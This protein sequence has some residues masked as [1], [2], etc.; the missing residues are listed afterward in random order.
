M[1]APFSLSEAEKICSRFQD[2]VGLKYNPDNALS[3][4]IECVAVTPY[5]ATNKQ[6][7][8]LYY[9]LLENYTQAEQSLNYRGLLFDV[10]VF[11]RNQNDELEHTDLSSWLFKNR[12]SFHS[13]IESSLKAENTI[14]TSS[15]SYHQ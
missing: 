8:I 5:D 4:N 6:K 1:P 13:L 15:N 2:L 12:P 10:L 9:L 11:S 3:G 14:T 7:F